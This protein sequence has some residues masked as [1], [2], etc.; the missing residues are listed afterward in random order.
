MFAFA[1]TRAFA[2]TPSP[3]PPAASASVPDARILKIEPKV[4]DL[5]LR[6]GDPIKLA[7]DVFGRFGVPD[8]N[9]GQRRGDQM[10][11]RELVIRRIRRT[12]RLLTRCQSEWHAGRD[13]RDLHR[14]RHSRSLHGNRHDPATLPSASQRRTVKPNNK[15]LPGAQPASK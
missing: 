11:Y 6:P 15:P 13:E 7:I 1:G 10:A 9:L 3:N 5:T 12:P 8:N 14:T 2:P 4:D